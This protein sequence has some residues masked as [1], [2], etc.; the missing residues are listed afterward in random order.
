MKNLVG[1]F[2]KTFF[3]VLFFSFVFGLNS[4]LSFAQSQETNDCNGY[5]A[6]QAGTKLELTQYDK[7][8]K[9]STLLKYK[10]KSNTPTSTGSIFL[11]HNQVMDKDG[12]QIV[13]GDYNIECKNGQIYADVTNIVS[14]MATVSDAEVTITG[15]KLV[16]PF[17]L[18]AGQLL[19]NVNYEVKQ[20]MANGGMTIMTLTVSITNRK[21]EGFET[22]TTP[23]GTFECVKIS[24]D[25]DAKMSIMKNK[26]RCVEYLAKGVGLVKWESFD[27]KGKK[28]SSQLLTKLE[29]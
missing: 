23:A 16:Y 6:Y 8:D 20:N 27:K 24:Y 17:E 18:K 2:S 19:D 1:S 26:T 22:V 12:K 29:R 5:F 25:S 7:K 11:F 14:S 21:V 3:L 13:E 4:T 15:D 10:V 28:E 9:V